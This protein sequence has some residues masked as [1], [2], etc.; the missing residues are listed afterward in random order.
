MGLK[1][2]PSLAIYWDFYLLVLLLRGVQTPGSAVCM[3]D[4]MPTCMNFFE[5]SS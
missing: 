3:L 1:S 5:T 4:T 2:P